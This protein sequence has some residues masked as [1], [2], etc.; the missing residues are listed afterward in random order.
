M[1]RF[2]ALL[3]SLCIAL[4]FLTGGLCPFSASAAVPQDSNLNFYR[5]F[6]S[7]PD[8]L[9]SYFE[10]NASSFDVW[11]TNSSIVLFCCYKLI[12]NVNYLNMLVFKCNRSDYHVNYYNDY[13]VLGINYKNRWD[14]YSSGVSGSRSTY[15]VSWDSDS[16]DLILWD[17]YSSFSGNTLQWNMPLAVENPFLISSFLGSLYS[18]DRQSSTLYNYYCNRP[19]YQGSSVDSP[20]LYSANL[21]SDDTPVIISFDAVIFEYGTKRYLTSSIYNLMSNMDPEKMYLLAGVSWNYSNGDDGESYVFDYYDQITV[22]YPPLDPGTVTPFPSSGR[23]YCFDISSWP[24]DAQLVSFT[25]Y[26]WYGLDDF[27]TYAE[28]SNLPLDVF[29]SFVPPVDQS[30]VAN[31]YFNQYI[32][33]TENIDP[34]IAQQLAN[35]VVGGSCRGFFRVSLSLDHYLVDDSQTLVSY[36]S[37]Y[38]ESTVSGQFPMI[39]WGLL[40]VVVIPSTDLNSYNLFSHPDDLYIDTY[41]FSNLFEMFDAVIVVPSDPD[42]LLIEDSVLG[43][44]QARALGGFSYLDESNFPSNDSRNYGFLLMNERAV[45]KGLLF[46]FSDSINKVYD[47]MT[48]YVSSHDNWISSQILWTSSVYAQ[49]QSIVNSLDSIT[50][51]LNL[52]VDKLQKLVDNTDSEEGHVW[53]LPLLNFIS[54]FTPS[55][56]DFTSSIESVDSYWDSLPELPSPAVSPPALPTLI[57]MIGVQNE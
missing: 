44:L 43:V 21:Y 8:E 9:Q 29:S 46:N 28:A 47:I 10:T 57:P 36:W 39:K 26:N 15:I 25:F 30:S 23:V 20:L 41:S 45:Q 24:E 19:V 42:W 18:P 38:L 52:I 2:I 3:L 22:F 1:R 31:Y 7:M 12:D 33:S 14:S 17:D 54:R 56:S 11:F 27:E 51:S 16:Y 4:S 40:D 55:I 34:I 49:L 6:E 50:G 13:G 37:P 32:T 53:F 35:N 48:Q 5:L